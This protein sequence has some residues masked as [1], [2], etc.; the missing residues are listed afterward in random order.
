MEGTLDRTSVETIALLEARL[1]RIER[2]LYGSSAPS[3]RPLDKPAAVAL[4]ELE[5]RFA[6]LVRRKQDYANILKLYKAHPS[7]F[8]APP[9]DSPPTDLS[10]EALRALVLSFAS[11]FPSTASALTAVTSDTPVPDPKLSAEL[12]SLLPRMKGVEA[13]QLAQEAEIAEL[14]TRSEKALREW[15]EGEVLEYGQFVADVEGRVEKVEMGI[16]R[17]ERFREMEEAAV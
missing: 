12:A 16:R 3:S 17:V 6:N 9:P 10:P 4:A 11:S 7:L 8:Q 5:R 15:Y 1:L 13:M 14:R 2:I